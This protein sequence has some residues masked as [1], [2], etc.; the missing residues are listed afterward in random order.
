MRTVAQRFDNAVGVYC[1][2]ARPGIIR[3]G[4]TVR[5]IGVDQNA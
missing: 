4:D 1:A 3:V 2:T 5:L